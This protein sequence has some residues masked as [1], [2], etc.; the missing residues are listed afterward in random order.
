[1]TPTLS[2]VVSWDV[3]NWA[4]ALKFWERY[5]G[6][7]D[8]EALDCL[9][10]GANGGGLSLWL[11]TLGHRVICSD[12]RDTQRTA[13]ALIDRYSASERVRFEDIDATNIPYEDAFDIVVFKS[14]LGGI[15]HDDQ[16]ARQEQAITSMYRA[17]RQG[18]RLL[19]AENLVGSRLHRY[20]RSAFVRW[21]TRWRYVSIEEMRGFLKPF[22]TVK[23]DTAGVLGALGRTE[24]QRRVLSR[25]DRA[26]LSHIV[27]PSWNYII[28]GVATK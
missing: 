4:A 9:E 2:E 20:F 17:L 7:T 18:G 15:G 10:V 13:G 14:V 3:G 22:R 16:A 21:G 28:Y 8:G 12:Q 27:P 1:M 24:R 11:A 19:F 25:F 26:G 5:G 23:F 6:L